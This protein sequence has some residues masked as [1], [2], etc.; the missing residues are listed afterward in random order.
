MDLFKLVRR[1]FL[2]RIFIFSTVILFFNYSHAQLNKPNASTYNHYNDFY[3]ITNYLGK[4]VVK[5]DR[6]GSKSY[7]VQNLTAPNNILF[8]DFPFGPSF[9]VLD[10]NQAKVFDTAGNSISIVSIANAKR[11]QDLVYDSTNKIIYTT[12]VDRGVIYKTT[13]GSAPNYLP[14]TTVWVS[15]IS[16]P[17]NI[18]LQLKQ[19]RILFVQDTMNANLMSVDLTTANVTVLRNTGLSLLSGLAQDSEGNYYISSQY[20]K[21][22]YQWNKYLTGSPKKVVGEPKPGDITVNSA[23]DEWVYCCILCGTVYIS[24]LHTFGPASEIMG[25][26][27]DSLDV[28]KNPLVKQLGTFADGNQFILELSSASG[29]FDSSMVLEVVSDTLQPAF[30]RIKIPNH[31]VGSKKYRYRYRSTKPAAIGFFELLYLSEQP[32]EQFSKD[33]IPVCGY[34]EEFLVPRDTQ[35]VYQYWSNSLGFKDSSR[36]I[37]KVSDS[38]EWVY[39]KTKNGDGC[40]AFDS[41]FTYPIFGKKATLQLKSDSILYCSNI[42]LNARYFIWRC[43]DTMLMDTTKEIVV[44]KT[45]HYTMSF[46][47]K[48]TQDCDYISDS[49]YVKY[50][51]KPL[52]NISRFEDFSVNIFPSPAKNN[53]QIHANKMINQIRVYNALGEIIVQR[54]IQNT[55]CELELA[56]F[57]NGVYV[58]QFKSADG[59]IYS[60][61]IVKSDQ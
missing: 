39:L 12:D 49:L 13:F 37:C 7:F 60:K 41:V 51:P 16:R 14:N 1:F 44:R 45:G 50:V 28:Y 24:R 15:G 18:I 3:Y 19:N 59:F 55:K 47:A 38:I 20:E 36:T 32:K 61:R 46:V 30:Q 11:L 29:N 23:K 52:S 58:I 43:N 48:A 33:S 40:I 21:N 17:S 22:I 27:G 10:S 42:P 4:S 26:P 6:F 31:L 57:N 35:F 25:C 2:P 53:V 56:G 54:N 34:G 9:I 8:A 5:M